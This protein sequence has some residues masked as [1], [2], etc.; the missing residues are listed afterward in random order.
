MTEATVMSRAKRM[1]MKAV[2]DRDA[3]IVATLLSNTE[4]AQEMSSAIAESVYQ[5]VRGQGG[6]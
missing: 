6:N 1:A 3:E 2:C 4:Q 5:A